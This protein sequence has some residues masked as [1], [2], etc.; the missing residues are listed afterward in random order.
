MESICQTIALNVRKRKIIGRDKPHQAPPPANNIF[1]E[2]EPEQFLSSHITKDI[3]WT[4]NPSGTRKSLQRL[5]PSQAELLQL[6]YLSCSPFSV[7]SMTD[8][9]FSTGCIKH[10][11]CAGRHNNFG[12]ALRQDCLSFEEGRRHLHILDYTR[13]LCL[14]FRFKL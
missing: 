1:G 5:L 4:N 13:V 9:P 8:F 10:P 11:E 12:R 3:S 7:G 2:H 6:Q 14:C